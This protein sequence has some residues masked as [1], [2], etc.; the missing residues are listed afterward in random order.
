RA[1]D[2]WRDR[3]GA[4]DRADLRRRGQE[5]DDVRCIGR[6]PPGRRGA[7]PHL[8]AP[9]GPDGEDRGGAQEGR[10]DQ[11]QAPL[12]RREGAAPALPQGRA[13]GT[14]VT[15]DRFACEELP[16]GLLVLSEEMPGVRSVSV[17]VWVRSGSVHESS[18]ELGASHLVEHMVFKGTERRSAKDLALVLERLGGSLDAYTTREHT[19]YHARVLDEHFDIALDVL[20]DM[21]LH[22][23]FR[24]QDLELEREVVLEE[25][26]TVED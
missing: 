6:D 3:A 13:P 20:A 18:A 17:G 22:P 12:D 15:R 1:G 25:I 21:V 5:H 16:G 19:A 9:G 2:D 23:L 10:H 4:R 24:E 11:G 14:G 26:S 8:G 7:L